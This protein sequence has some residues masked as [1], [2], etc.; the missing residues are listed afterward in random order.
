MTLL[1]HTPLKMKAQPT[2]MEL[3]PLSKALLALVPRSWTNQS[4]PS[5]LA[6]TPLLARLLQHSAKIQEAQPL[7]TKISQ[8]EV[9]SRITYRVHNTTLDHQP[10][11]AK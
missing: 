11:T 10:P 2:A 7:L 8:E 9:I 1:E 6:V 3:L 4:A 5:T